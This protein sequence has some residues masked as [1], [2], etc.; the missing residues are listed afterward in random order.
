MAF[1]RT[2]IFERF[3][4]GKS[5]GVFEKG[6][7]KKNERATSFIASSFPTVVEQRSPPT[8]W[9]MAATLG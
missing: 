5:E 8:I 3:R 1:R 7:G 6:Q 2:T 4:T 9:K